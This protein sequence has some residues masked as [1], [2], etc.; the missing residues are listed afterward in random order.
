M[1]YAQH[2]AKIEA[3]GK[4]IQRFKAGRI[5][6]A[7][8]EG[9]KE[10]SVCPCK[11]KEAGET[12]TLPASPVAALVDAWSAEIRRDTDI[13]KHTCTAHVTTDNITVLTEHPPLSLVDRD[14]HIIRE[15]LW[16]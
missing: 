11:H 15:F 5:R 3:W 4:N 16:E 7:A 12:T 14:L 1:P 10:G 2:L 8:K 13:H 9:R 6:K